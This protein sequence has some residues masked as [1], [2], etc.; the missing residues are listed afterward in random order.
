MKKIHSIYLFTLYS[1]IAVL[2]FLALINLF[3]RIFGIRPFVVLSGSMEPEIPTGG[4]IFVDTNISPDQIHTDDVITYALEDTTVTHRVIAE[5]VTTVTTKGDANEQADFSP[6]PRE[7]I[8]GRVLFDIPS[9]GYLYT[10]ISHP[11]FITVLSL[12]LAVNL[13][14]EAICSLKIMIK[15]KKKKEKLT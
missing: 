7:Q 12:L 2:F 13:I 5:T 3:P 6:V 9:L 10:K 14:I 1:I 15:T 11:L 8:L 4:V